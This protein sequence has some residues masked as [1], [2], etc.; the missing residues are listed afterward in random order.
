MIM[1]PSSNFDLVM[2][3][4]LIFD[5][6]ICKNDGSAFTSFSTSLYKYTKKFNL[7][8]CFK[9]LELVSFIIGHTF[10]YKVLV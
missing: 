1:L 10:K 8:E 2:F 7:V 3:S 4:L 9:S 6:I 5:C